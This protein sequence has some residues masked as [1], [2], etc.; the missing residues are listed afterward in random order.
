MLEYAFLMYK[1]TTYL[2]VGSELLLGSWGSASSADS[3]PSSAPS[4]TLSSWHKLYHFLSTLQQYLHFHL[5]DISWRRFQHSLKNQVR[6]ILDLEYVHICYITDALDM[7]TTSMCKT[8]L[9]FI[10][11]ALLCLV[12]FQL[13]GVG[14]LS[15]SRFSTRVVAGLH[16]GV[17][18]K[19]LRAGAPPLRQRPGFTAPPQPRAST[20]PA[21]VL[22]LVL[23]AELLRSTGLAYGTREAR[24]N[25]A[26]AL[27]SVVGL[28]D[29][30]IRY[31]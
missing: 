12:A 14:A 31:T 23:P 21:S 19:G 18:A 8:Y 20:P 27:A 29:A 16:R 30:Y 7:G 1:V 15:L 9:C 11:L 4:P 5:S 24:Y 28:A 10:S 26:E 6:D 22:A 13:V 17:L 3:S 2:L 25:T